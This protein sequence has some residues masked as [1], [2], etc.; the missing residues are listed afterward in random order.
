MSTPHEN[1]PSIE[2]R[3]KQKKKPLILVYKSKDGHK[4]W[5]GVAFDKT[6]F[7]SI[8]SPPFEL[9]LPKPNILL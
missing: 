2:P 5:L 9:S 1:K 3:N 6:A 4:L 7:V 8:A